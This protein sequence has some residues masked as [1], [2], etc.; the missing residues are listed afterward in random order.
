MSFAVFLRVEV[1]MSK[2][3][4]ILDDA[5]A[6]FVDKPVCM[7][8]DSLVKFDVIVGNDI[9]LYEPI[10]SDSLIVQTV[11][12]ECLF[13]TLLETN[14]VNN[15][16]TTFRSTHTYSSQSMCVAVIQQPDPLV[17]RFWT[18]EPNIL[19]DVPVQSVRTSVD[20]TLSQLRNNSSLQDHF[21]NTASKKLWQFSD[22]VFLS[23][24]NAQRPMKMIYTRA[25]DS[26]VVEQMI[27]SLNVRQIVNIACSFLCHPVNYRLLAEL[28]A[29]ITSYEVVPVRVSESVNVNDVFLVSQPENFG[30]S[31][32]SEVITMQQLE[33]LHVRRFDLKHCVGL[34]ITD[35]FVKCRIEN[36]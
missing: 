12:Q 22:T 32:T 28:S 30:M 15:R 24:L 26:L 9:S 16:V 5:V 18:F 17:C 8:S 21:I 11:E 13:N 23:L 10:S 25:L 29:A 19:I 6:E 27:S 7:K 31:V 34:L 20:V 1:E 2:F 14:I 3:D 33:S 4:F 35:N 36:G